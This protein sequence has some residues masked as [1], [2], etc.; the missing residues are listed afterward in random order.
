M[1]PSDLAN[2]YRQRLQARR[3]LLLAQI[4]AQRGGQ[5]SRADVERRLQHH[6]L[7]GVQRRD[8]PY[9]PI[10]PT[11]VQYDAVEGLHLV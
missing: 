1:T 10:A 5:R 4:A 9:A 7:P 6:R 2:D 11:N 3:A 8:P